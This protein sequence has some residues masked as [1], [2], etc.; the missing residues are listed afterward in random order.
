ML[1]IVVDPVIKRDPVTLCTS[2]II[3]PIITPVPPTKN[4]VELPLD[5][6]S[7]PVI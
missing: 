5:T 7:E 6:I 1:L 3:L 2:D 4:S